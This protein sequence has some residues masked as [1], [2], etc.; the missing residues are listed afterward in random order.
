[1][2]RPNTWSRPPHLK[3]KDH[4]RYTHG[5]A[6]TPFYLRY[7]AMINR[8][9]RPS[10]NSYAKYG[11]RGITVCDRWLDFQNFYDDMYESFEVHQREHGSDTSLE[12]VDNSLGYSP[13]NCRWATAHE[14]A[15]NRRQPTIGRN[16]KL[17]PL[18]VVNIKHCKGSISSARLGQLYGTSSTSVLDI[19]S[20]KTWRN[21]EAALE[22]TL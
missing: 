11:A 4:P 3:G 6:G 9:T 8:C 1:M 22:E 15:L 10:V 17:S 18:Q 21:L 14:Q 2:R 12:R 7:K 20:G 19:W 5:M 16:A 13:Q